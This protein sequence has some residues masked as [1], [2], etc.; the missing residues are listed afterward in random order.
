MP[1]KNKNKF[2]EI[3]KEASIEEIA[4][5]IHSL[6]K[7]AKRK[8]N[9]ALQELAQT[10]D[11]YPQYLA[12][13]KY[14]D[15]LQSMQTKLTNVFSKLNGHI[16]EKSLLIFRNDIEA[17]NSSLSF[18][19]ETLNELIEREKDLKV[20][21]ESSVDIIFRLSSTGKLVYISP[22][23]E[24]I[25]GYKQEEVLTKSFISFLPQTEARK[26]LGALT[27]FF[28]ERRISNFYTYLISKEGN[29]VPVEIN[30]MLIE[31]NGKFLGQGTIRDITERI[32]TDNKLK[33][34]ES[35]FTEV[36]Q[37]SSDGM[38][39]TDENGIVLLCNDAYADMVEMKRSEIE[40]KKFS[41]VYYEEKREY[42]L[43]RYIENFKSNTIRSK[44]EAS[45]KLW[46]GKVKYF[47]I[48]SSII[49]NAENKRILLNIFRDVTERHLQEIELK[50]KDKLIHGV[51]D[52]TAKLISNLS[53]SDAIVNSLQILGTSAEVDRVYIYENYF[54][55]NLKKLCIRELYEWSASEKTQQ[56]DKLKTEEIS[57]SRFD[58]IDMYN[59]LAN[60]K[61]LRLNVDELSSYQKR[62]FI[63]PNIKSILLAPIFLENDFYGFLGFDS[64]IEK[65]IWTESDES[66]IATIAVSIGGAIQRERARD[67][68]IKKNEELDEALKLANAAAKAKS[69][70]LALMSHEIRTPMNGV[71]GMTG[72]LLDSGLTKEQFEYVETIRVSGEQ[73][74]VIIND[75]LDFSKIESEKLELEKIPFDIKQCIEE[76]FDLFTQQ[77]SEKKIEMLYYINQNVPNAI[78]ADLTRV[79][80]ILT[81]LVSNAVKFTESGEI[82]INVDAKH[83][84]SNIFEFTF[85]VKDTGIGIPEEKIEKLFQPF[86]QVDSSTT[87]L[88]GGTGLG[89]VISKR[90]TE[91]MGGK[92]W[93]ESKVNQ[94][95]TFYFTFITE[96][97]DIPI[98]RGRVETIPELTNKKVLV[99][100][101]NS[102]NRKI[103]KIQLENWGMIPYEVESGLLALD[104]LRSGMKFDLGVLDYQMPEMNG[105]D[106]TRAIRN[107]GKDYD[108]PIILLTSIGRKEDQKILD[109]LKIMQFL[110]KP[111]KQSQ[112]YDSLVK[113]FLGKSTTETKIETTLQL[114]TKLSLQFP[115]K[116]LLAEDNVVNQK[117][118]SR[119]LSK[120]GYRSDVV[121]NGN[122]VIEAVSKI[123][124]DL[125]FMDVHMPEMDG[126]EASI[127]IN[128]MFLPEKRPIIIA[129][130]ANA[131]QGDREAC[132]EAGMDDYL[133]KPVRIEELQACLDKWGT[134]IIAHRGNVLERLKKEKLNTKII[135]EDKIPF[136]EELQEED[137]LLFFI[138]LIDIYLNETPQNIQK[139]FDAVSRKDLSA[140][141]FYAHKLKGASVSLGIE[142][143]NKIAEELENLGKSETIEDAE[144][145]CIKLSK[146][147]ESA[148]ED[149]KLIRAKYKN[150]L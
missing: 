16:D 41:N 82:F 26:A 84:H 7:A 135:N 86:S 109:E 6:P 74:L 49:N 48:T 59:K 85:S 32:K 75:I 96:S 125:I 132:I 119:M 123:K 90:L 103:L 25:L 88:Y 33:S 27:K 108:F 57:Y 128:K 47:E 8:F 63:D 67:L 107:F 73:L 126:L 118:A 20:L 106:L 5:L 143:V 127:K 28:K 71:I 138:E 80:Q 51:A 137:D 53:F 19:L 117:V 29:L 147:F 13:E 97:V 121:A 3:I 44:Y 144:E 46:N 1:E 15:I 141:S 100:D 145:L 56:I 94:G 116:I 115:L 31:R 76:T 91:L 114:N 93:V 54:N 111:I 95:T 58:S 34:A 92:M 124:Y 113:V 146:I 9:T 40:N 21:V 23:V 112:F 77:T 81:N 148:S 131:M 105:I 69:E 43:T 22:S 136:L 60:G 52:A 78:L 17:L 11:D 104:L 4:D 142:E 98:R 37:K 87:R 65:R 83:I 12:I 35:T 66:V 130:T 133:S 102:T 72:L 89:L 14:V 99:V 50:R 150:A 101:D 18:Q 39:L 68:L 64:C 55:E 30:G 70:F 2:A 45:L 24:Y 139:V 122:E 110:S 149:L 120:L 62:V 10:S 140:L 129:M 38:R 42:I 61:I 79:R 36:W 134:K